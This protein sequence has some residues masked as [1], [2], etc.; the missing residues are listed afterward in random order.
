[1]KGI[2]FIYLYMIL[3]MKELKFVYCNKIYI[4]KLIK[5]NIFIIEKNTGIKI[6]ITENY[7]N[8]DNSLLQLAKLVC[9]LI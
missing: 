9:I 2:F 3:F 8:I 5:N 4:L 6:N 1:M 7:L